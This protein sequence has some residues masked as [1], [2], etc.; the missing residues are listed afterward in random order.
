MKRR[1]HG[2]ILLE[3]FIAISL[4][5]MALL[6]ISSYPYKIFEKERKKL[7]AI[8][9]KRAETLVFA[10][11]VQN[12]TDYITPLLL[13][14]DEILIPLGQESIDLGKLGRY[15]FDVEIKITTENKNQTSYLLA[16]EVCLIPHGSKIFIPEPKVHYLFVSR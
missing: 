1:R 11:F 10:R 16:C 2:F 6:P 14:Q 9:C 15:A 4:L 5:T 12:L 7:L 3:V 8:E 13:E